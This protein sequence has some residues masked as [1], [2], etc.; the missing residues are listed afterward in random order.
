MGSD[1][2][3]EARLAALA[4]GDVLITCSVALGEVL[5]GI[6]RLAPGKRRSALEQNLARARSRVLIE[7]VPVAAAQRYAVTKWQCQRDGVALNENDLWI[8]ASAL[9]LSATL[10]T[11]DNDFGRV[12]GL[13]TQDWHA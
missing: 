12:R 3:T 6:E 4:A 11:R 1:P 8:A 2:P 5:Y 13:L 10:V 9:A 7:A